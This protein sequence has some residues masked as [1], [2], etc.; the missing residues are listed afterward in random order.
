MSTS[1]GK[2]RDLRTTNGEGKVKLSVSN[3][4]SAYKKAMKVESSSGR[5]EPDDYFMLYT[6]KSKGAELENE[7]GPVE[8]L[9]RNGEPR[10]YRSFRTILLGF[11]PGLI[12]LG[13]LARLTG[14]QPTYF[15]EKTNA[16]NVY[17]V[18]FGW[19]WTTA[20]YLYHLIQNKATRPERSLLRFAGGTI[21]WYFVNSWFFGP[22]VVDRVFQWTGGSCSVSDKDRA[23]LCKLSSGDWTGGHD[24]SGHCMMLIHSSLILWEE[25]MLARPSK[26]TLASRLA[27]GLLLLWGYMLLITAIYFH[28]FVENLTGCIVGIAYWGVVYY[29]QLIA[30]LSVR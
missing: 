17:F 22:S 21:Y 13:A 18:K 28:T 1:L 5:D 24:I 8:T 12:I 14:P 9:F 11:Y 2:P 15:Q 27:I 7:P 25:V 3:G 20:A 19:G 16:F 26:D 30:F 29:F 6:S 23:T 10:I 4:H